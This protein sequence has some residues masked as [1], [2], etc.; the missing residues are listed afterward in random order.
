M[1]N[2]LEL[3]CFSND[4]TKDDII[5]CNSYAFEHGLKAINSLPNNLPII[6]KIKNKIESYF[7][8]DSVNPV[9]D[10]RNYPD[11]IKI[12]G[13][14]E[15]YNIPIY[16]DEIISDEIIEKLSNIKGKIRFCYNLTYYSDLNKIKILN[17]KIKSYPVEQEVCIYF[18]K[19]PTFDEINLFRIAK[20]IHGDGLKTVIMGNFKPVFFKIHEKALSDKMISGIGTS[21]KNIMDVII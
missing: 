11:I 3:C 7:H 4:Y 14:H 12:L 6:Q 16:I 21:L 13:E 8:V 5:L 10:I 20:I 1:I 9:H 2:K 18:G 15:N 17:A 19:R